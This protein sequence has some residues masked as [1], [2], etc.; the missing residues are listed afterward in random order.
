MAPGSA[1]DGAA[2]ESGAATAPE[3]LIEMLKDV[4]RKK[5]WLEEDELLLKN[6]IRHL[7]FELSKTEKKAEET[8]LRA[9]DVKVAKERLARGR[10]ERGG[11]ARSVY[12]M[13]AE[14]SKEIK[15]Q[16]ETARAKLQEARARKEDEVRREAERLRVERETLK[17]HMSEAKLRESDATRRR[18]KERAEAAARAKEAELRAADQAAR[19][20]LA[21]VREELLRERSETRAANAE[22]ARLEQDEELWIERLKGDLLKQREAYVELERELALDKAQAP[23]LDVLGNQ[24]SVASAFTSY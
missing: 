9:G 5:K 21:K 10:E 16:Q 22:I 8:K 23:A 13:T 2:P 24:E 6:R 19:E 12:E 11:A 3:Q 20:A 14:R 18:V 15:R 1:Q 17:L 7:Q 4:P